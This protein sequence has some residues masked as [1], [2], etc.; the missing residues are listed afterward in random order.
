MPRVGKKNKEGVERAKEK[1]N[2]AIEDKF[3]IRDTTTEDKYTTRCRLIPRYLFKPFE[4]PHLTKGVPV[5]E[6]ISDSM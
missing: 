2:K 1:R 4:V 6:S 5:N 3:D